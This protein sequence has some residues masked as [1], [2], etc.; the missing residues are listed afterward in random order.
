[1]LF[2]PHGWWHTVIN[3]EDAEY[4]GPSIAITQNY[5]SSTNLIDV[6]RFLRT[7]KKKVLVVFET[8]ET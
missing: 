4:N 3:V 1:M 6:F 2:V 7:K 8:I 5:V